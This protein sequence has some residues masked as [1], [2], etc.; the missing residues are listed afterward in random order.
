MKVSSLV[1]GDYRYHIPSNT[2]CEGDK[3]MGN[4]DGA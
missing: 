3:Q 1:L 2:C 4:G